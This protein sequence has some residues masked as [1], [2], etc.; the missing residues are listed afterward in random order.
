[1]SILISLSNDFKIEKTHDS[2][3]CTLRLVEVGSYLAA[4]KMS[5]FLIVTNERSWYLHHYNL[6]LVN[7]YD[8]C[9]AQI[10]CVFQNVIS[11]EVEI[12]A[13]FI[14]RRSH[15]FESLR[16]PRFEEVGKISVLFTKQTPTRQRTQTKCGHIQVS[17]HTCGTKVFYMVFSCHWTPTPTLSTG[18]LHPK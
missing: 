2:D 9:G 10:V 1:M 11:V 17:Q 7:F 4:M 16:L 8:T 15:T 12:I 18:R 5:T 13:V 14:W 3:A 6:T